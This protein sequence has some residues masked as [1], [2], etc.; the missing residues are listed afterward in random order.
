MSLCRHHC[1]CRAHA[2][3]TTPSPLR[4]L[5]E[6]RQTRERLMRHL[7]IL[8]RR[9][10]C[11]GE[12]LAAFTSFTVLRQHVIATPRAVH[13]NTTRDATPY[14]NMN[15][16]HTITTAHAHIAYRVIN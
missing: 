16:R 12:R 10:T 15:A 4:P 7:L 6:R 2:H 3:N 9:R 5:R 14:A 1:H 11:V 13:D 8:L